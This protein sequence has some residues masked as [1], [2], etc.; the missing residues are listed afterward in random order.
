[1]EITAT[2][3]SCNRTEEDDAAAALIVLISS[4][5]GIIGNVLVILS[6]FLTEYLRSE[7]V[8]FLVINLAMA[9]FLNCCCI[10][11]PCMANLYTK[12]W[13]LRKETCRIHSVIM[14][15]IMTVSKWTLAAIS[16]DRA[17]ALKIPLRYPTIVTKFKI[18]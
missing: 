6:Y 2:K 5:S 1:M 15:S 13:H 16:L 9:D 8:N 18:R 7:P 3:Q 12:G 14:W 11:V 4:I 10:Q 17:I